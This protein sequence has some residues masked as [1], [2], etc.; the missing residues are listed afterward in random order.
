[1]TMSALYMLPTYVR[2]ELDD[3]R[4]RADLRLI[5]TA[6]KL[7]YTVT[8]DNDHWHNSAVFGRGSTFIW[9]G[10]GGWRAKDLVMGGNGLRYAWEGR[11]YGHGFDNL[12]RALR[13][14]AA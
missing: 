10:E 14:E 12:L 1:M 3:P 11:M 8:F 6:E 5:E 7:G 9:Q 2:E 13:T 4:T